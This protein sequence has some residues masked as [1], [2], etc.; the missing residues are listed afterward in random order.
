MLLFTVNPSELCFIPGLQPMLTKFMRHEAP[1]LSLPFKFKTSLFSGDNIG[2]RPSYSHLVSPI[3]TVLS[4]DCT[5]YC[6][7][8]LWLP[9]FDGA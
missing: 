5:Q 6:I 7:V 1:Q 2:E 4:S 3:G 9:F 8:F